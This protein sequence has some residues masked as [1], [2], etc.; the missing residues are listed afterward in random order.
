MP[1]HGNLYQPSNRHVLGNV[2][3]G[4]FFIIGLHGFFSTFFSAFSFRFS[5]DI[6]SGENSDKFSLLE[7]HNRLM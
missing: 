2:Y 4:N 5:F 1:R 6:N 3:E 7:F